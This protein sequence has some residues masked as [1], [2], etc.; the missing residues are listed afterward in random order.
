MSILAGNSRLAL[1][2]GL[3]AVACT[4]NPR[5][6][7]EAA[8][9]P[10]QQET[11]ANM[12][13]VSPTPVVAKVEPAMPAT[14]PVTPPVPTTPETPPEVP[15]SPAVQGM[16]V[17]TLPPPVAA[18][19]IEHV[20]PAWE[21]V[22]KLDKEVDLQPLASG[23]L[24]SIGGVFHEFGPDNAPVEKAAADPTT[25]RMLFPATIQGSWPDDAW[26]IKEIMHERDG[27]DLSFCKWRSN[28]RWVAQAIDGETKWDGYEFVDYRWSPRT[29][30]LLVQDSEGVASFHRL[31]GKHPAPE[32]MTHGEGSVLDAFESAGGMVFLFVQPPADSGGLEILRSCKQDQAPGCERSGGLMLPTSEKRSYRLGLMAAR[33][34]W[35][36]SVSATLEP[37]ADASE[38]HYIVH[39]E[40][41]GWKVEAVPGGGDIR[42]ML[43]APDGGLWIVVAAGTPSLW[44]RSDAGKW[45]AVDLPADLVGSPKIELALRDPTHV[46]VAGNVGD[47]HAIHAAPAALQSPVQAP[48]PSPAG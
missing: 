41:G 10:V 1:G 21:L 3:L 14:P 5:P 31:A 35:S 44:H 47:T 23:V 11:K 45:V 38:E 33:N 13:A 42:Q 6:E 39:Y 7:P 43:A 2:L 16:P 30:F 26:W 46:W 22:T 37:G 27:S 36:I 4:A 12:P 19:G 9:V 18:E 20:A 8:A 34:R 17:A 25:L 48:E 15:G 32:P 28:N 29:G 24:A 40:T